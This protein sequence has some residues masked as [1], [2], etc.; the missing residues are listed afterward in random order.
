M[1][2]LT[3]IRHALTEWNV[4]GRFQGHT[5]IPLSEAGEKQ[6]RALGKH[7]GKVSDGV[8]LIYSSPLLRAA[9]TAHLIFPGRDILLDERLKELNFGLFE[10]FTQLENEAHE[11][12]G[13]WFED[14]FTREAP[15][16]ESYQNLRKRASAW[17]EALP[18]VPHVVA[19]THSGAIQMLVSA[20]LGVEKPTWRKRIFLRHTGV[21]RILF[22]GSDA[23]IE[24]VND[25][26]HLSRED[27]DPFAD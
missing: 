3:L 5:D 21:T 15:G 7:L 8:D 25:T 14:P 24:R 9:Q 26:R 6:A 12:W 10:G 20:V 23:L 2:Q 1:R 27:G 22:R 19:V 18:E 11:R 13:W 16:G 17:M 4:T